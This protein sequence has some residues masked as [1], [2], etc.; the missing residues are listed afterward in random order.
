MTI[1]N[2]KALIAVD[3]LRTLKQKKT[4]G[5]LKNPHQLIIIE[6]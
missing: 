5:E 1:D 6:N 4:T 3:E 2:I